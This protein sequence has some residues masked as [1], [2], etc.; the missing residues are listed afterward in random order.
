VDHHK[1]FKIDA[2]YV[3]GMGSLWTIFFFFIVTWLMPFG[4][5]FL[6]VLFCLGLCL[7]VCGLSA[8][9]GLRLVEDGA[10]VPFMLFMEGKE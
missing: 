3:R 9:C 1:Q 10:Y 5:P 2:T 6:V 7:D 4:L 8:V